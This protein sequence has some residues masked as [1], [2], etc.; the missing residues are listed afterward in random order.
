MKPVHA[1][2]PVLNTPIP[3]LVRRKKGRRGKGCLVL[4]IM[5]H[6]LVGLGVLG[7]TLF[8]TL[9]T[10]FGSAVPATVTGRYSKDDSDGDTQHYLNY[11]YTASGA[12]HDKT[13]K[14]SYAT[15]STTTEGTTLTVKVLPF[16][17]EYPYL[18]IAGNKTTPLG[19]M[20]CF[21]L[22]WN[23]ILAVFWWTLVLSPHL[24]RRLVRWGVPVI[25]RVLHK[26]IVKGSYGDSHYVRYEFMAP[27]ASVTDRAAFYPTVAAEAFEPRAESG[28]V[29]PDDSYTTEFASLRK[30]A[31]DEVT[32]PDSILPMPNDVDEIAHKVGWRELLSKAQAQAQAE[33]ARIA[34]M[35]TP[36][37][38]VSE[39]MVN[40][41]EWYKVQEGETITVLCDHRRPKRN[42]A[43]LFA[44]Y[45]VVPRHVS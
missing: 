23:G 6:T 26:R 11:R 29:H 15:Y 35:T 2:E 4:F 5:P 41:D 7:L 21:T 1:I 17:Q 24:H 31:Q 10:L 44:D 25:G 20:W 18:N 28:A 3:R 36:G 33:E 30:D 32:S 43:Y 34:A 9:V 8:M 16:L 22:F 39:V 37:A 27:T 38:I 45:E 13:A 40:L 42:V 19:F 12:V 14:V